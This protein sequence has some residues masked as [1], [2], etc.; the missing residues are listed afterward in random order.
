MSFSLAVILSE[1]AR[2]TPDH[3]VAVFDG[4]RRGGT[5]ERPARAP[6]IA[7][8]LEDSGALVLIIWEGVPAEAVKGAEAAGITTDQAN[9]HEP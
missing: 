6:E 2:R 9:E 7:Y 3:P 8:H 1:S 5:A 4:G